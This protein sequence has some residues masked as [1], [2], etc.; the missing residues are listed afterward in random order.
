MLNKKI[1]SSMAL[2]ERIA[3]AGK[4]MTKEEEITL[5]NWEKAH[6]TGGGEFAT[7]DWPGWPA[8]IARL[9]H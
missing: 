1:K 6:V 9:S 3:A 5:L 4:I 8:V 7:S 2:L